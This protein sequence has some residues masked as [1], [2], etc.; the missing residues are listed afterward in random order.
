MILKKGDDNRDVKRLQRVLLIETDGVFG[1]GTENALKSKYNKIICDDDVWNDVLAK[2]KNIVIQGYHCPFSK[3]KNNNTV[4]LGESIKTLYLPELDK[5]NAPK[6]IKL[7]ATVMAMSEGF[8]KG[9][10]S[11]R[12]NNPGNIGNTDS[13]GNNNFKTL[14]EG[15]QAQ[16]NYLTRVAKGEHSAYK[17]GQKTIKPYFSKEIADNQKTYGGAFPY[18]AGYNFNYKG[19]LGGFIKIY[20]TMARATNGY[21]STIISYFKMNGIEIDENTKLSDILNIK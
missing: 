6:G 7:L 8:V 17:F 14:K 12:T 18:I 2:E 4:V 13:G 10:R 21:L 5:I 20:A 15:I 16:I 3:I 11:F 9:S 1:S 19:E